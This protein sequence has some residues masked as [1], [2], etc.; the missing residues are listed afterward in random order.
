MT[1]TVMPIVIDALGTI[2]KG[3]V[4]EL[5]DLERRG[6]EETIKTTALLSSTRILRRVL[7]T[8]PSN[9]SG[10]SSLNADVKI[11]EGTIIIIMIAQIF[12]IDQL[13]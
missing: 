2:S 8:C 7:E 10:K 11:Y 4:N 9:S 1:V 5:E 3:F 13:I 12:N 6:Q